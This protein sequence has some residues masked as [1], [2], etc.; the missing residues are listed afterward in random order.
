MKTPQKFTLGEMREMG[1]RG[2][3]VY[4]SGYPCSFFPFYRRN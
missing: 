3:L 1:I 2:R 4:C